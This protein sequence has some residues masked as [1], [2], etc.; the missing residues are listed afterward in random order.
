LL[1]FDLVAGNDHIPVYLP[2]FGQRPLPGNLLGAR[3]EVFGVCSMKM[4]QQGLIT[5]LWFYASDLESINVLQAAAADPYQQP[6]HPI[7]T[8]LKYDTLL[9]FGERV[10]IAGVVT[11]SVPPGRLFLRDESRSVPVDLMQPWEHNDPNGR[12]LD[13]PVFPPLEPGNRIEVVGYR[14]VVEGRF[15]VVDAEF[16]IVGHERSPAALWVERE[17][18]LNPALDGELVSLE[19]RLIESELRPTGKATN[20]VLSLLSGDTFYEAELVDPGSAPIK[21]QK[22]SL[23]R[24]T[25]INTVQTDPWRRA[26]FFRLL[27]RDREDVAV[28]QVPPFWTLRVAARIVA[29]GALL[30][31]AALVWIVVLRRQVS[32]TTADLRQANERLKQLNASKSSFISMVTHEIRTPLA[33]I[34]SSEEILERYLDRLSPEKRRRHL[35]TIRHSVARM[36]MLVQDVLMFNRAEAG[37]L[38]FRPA[39]LDLAKFCRQLVD[40]VQSATSRRCPIRLGVAESNG[41]V[42]VDETLMHHVLVNLLTNAVKF[43]KT[44]DEVRLEVTVQPHQATFQ[45]QDRGIGIPAPDLNRIFEPFYRSGNAAH[46]GGTGLGLAIV[47][48]CVER[49]GGTLEIESREGGGSRFTVRVPIS[50]PEVIDSCCEKQDKT[51]AANIV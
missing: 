27:L 23:L 4:T 7:N 42:G 24:V 25:G 33:L 32:L 35:E 44:G 30:I 49:H 47:K 9:S 40:Q 43:S 39:R 20:L 11:H 14:S 50:S 19:A 29:V 17:D 38:E 31:L 18:A 6:T 51:Q 48:R 15:T 34:L 16:R 5:G 2:R 22:N 10:K 37:P 26:R 46:I 45:V 13:P 28:L 8:L 36:V 12:Y 21:A 41:L 3:V 1:E